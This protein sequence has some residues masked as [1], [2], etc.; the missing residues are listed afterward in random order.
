MELGRIRKGGK[1]ILGGIHIW[2]VERH[3]FEG[4]NIWSVI[5]SWRDTHLEGC[6]FGGIQILNDNHLEGFTFRG[7]YIWRDTHLER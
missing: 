4:I 3:I 7:M 6:T 5:H 1:K 2:T